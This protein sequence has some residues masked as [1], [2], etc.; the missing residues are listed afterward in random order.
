VRQQ[1]PKNLGSN[2]A[3][4]HFLLYVEGAK[5][6]PGIVNLFLNPANIV[7]FGGNDPRFIQLEEPGKVFLL[8]HLIPAEQTFDYPPHGRE[9]HVAGKCEIL[10]ACWSEADVHCRLL[11][12]IV[13][14]NITGLRCLRRGWI[15]NWRKIAITLK[16][17]EL[18]RIS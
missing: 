11:E 1:C 14:S 6:N 2:A 12:L 13:R 4:L 10:I 7:P 15:P 16:I 3:P 17:P 5:I 9:V 8:S 18:E